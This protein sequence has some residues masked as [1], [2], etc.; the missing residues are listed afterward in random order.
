MKNTKKA[1]LIENYYKAFLT[2]RIKMKH[3]KQIII[4]LLVEDDCEDQKLEELNKQ[5]E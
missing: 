3:Y 2:E 1:R 5:I 4:N